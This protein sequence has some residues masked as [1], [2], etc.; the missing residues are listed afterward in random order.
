MKQVPNHFYIIF[1]TGLNEWLHAAEVVPSFLIDKR[2]ADCLAH[3][4]YPHVVQSFVIFIRMPVVVRSRDL[5]DP[6]ASRI[7]SCCAFKPGKEETS[8]HV[9]S[10]LPIRVG[11]RDEDASN[12]RSLLARQVC[13]RP[14]QVRGIRQPIASEPV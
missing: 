7:V 12:A 8:K 1:P 5:V 11:F 10:F 14:P 3:C 2:P 6:F 9:T 4:V 13:F